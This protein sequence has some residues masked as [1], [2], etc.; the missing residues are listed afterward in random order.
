VLG[1]AG[2]S[3]VTA[4]A[5][6]G[7]PGNSDVDWI[8]V[9]AEALEPGEA[10]GW[11]ASP[12]CG[13]VVTFCGTVRDHSP[14]RPGVVGLVYEAYD[15]YVVPKLAEVGVEARR[16]WPTIGRLVMVHRVGALAVGETAVVVAVSAP[17]RPS[18]FAAASFCIDTLKATVPIWKLETWDGG[19]SWATECRLG[20]SGL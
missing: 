8:A 2:L 17:H 3:P 7:A 13:A 6:P 19:E 9:T 16:R 12:G 4:P 18:A 5:G 15:E 14:G 1:R 11:A 20:P 10:I